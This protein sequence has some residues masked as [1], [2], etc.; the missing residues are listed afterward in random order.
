MKNYSELF[1]TLI[2]AYFLIKNLIYF[3]IPVFSFKSA[4]LVDALSVQRQ[5]CFVIYGPPLTEVLFY[6]NFLQFP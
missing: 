1:F 2:L 6:K 5:E 4:F 3:F